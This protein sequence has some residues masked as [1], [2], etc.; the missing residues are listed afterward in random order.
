MASRV[1]GRVAFHRCTM[2]EYVRHARSR[3]LK[4]QFKR[5]LFADIMVVKQKVELGSTLNKHIERAERVNNSEYIENSGVKT[6]DAIAASVVGAASGVI[7]NAI[8]TNVARAASSVTAGTIAANGADA[9]GGA[10]EAPKA[11]KVK[12]S[13]STMR[14]LLC[15][16][17]GGFALGF[18]EFAM[19]G[20][21][22][23]VAQGMDVSI[24]YA[25]NYISAYAVGVCFGTLFLVFGHN[26]SPKKLLFFFAVLMVLGNGMAAI[27]PNS[28][29]LLVARFVAGLPH[30][31]YFGAATLV[32]KELAE[33]GKQAQAVSTMVLGQT[34]ANMVGVPFGTL[35]AEFISWRAAF[36]FVAVWAAVACFCLARFIPGTVRIAQTTMTGQFSFLRSPRPWFVLGA[37]F[38]GNI[39]IFCWWSYVSP[40]FMNLGGFSSQNLPALLMLCGFG[41]VLG[42]LAGGRWADKITPGRMAAAGQAL[43]CVALLLIFFVTGPF[44]CAVAAFL[45]SFAMFSMSSPQQLL[46]VKV[47][48]GGGEMIGSACV[49]VAYNAANAI[50]ALVGQSV[51]NAGAAY[52][53]PSLAG[54]PF[55][56][57]AAVLLLVF[58]LRFEYA[59]GG[60]R[61]KRFSRA[62]RAGRAE[63]AAGR[64]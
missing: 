42:S 28:P 50:G 37:V 21:L 35:L 44:A 24:P 10:S 19:M 1:L 43:S 7:E 38:A 60:D 57:T 29:A 17:M 20:I 15:L 41:M 45:C 46:M 22:P 61:D 4:H 34:A 31:A 2:R 13:G 64:S 30:G 49:Q 9:A 51:L 32:A 59:A 53:Y 47:G 27:A 6:A 54:A 11:R 5:G 58:A 16:A 52:N 3:S 36:A 14:S 39:G 55:A 33:P 62:V 18:A 12:R 63:S 26:I 23:S 8:A 48:A 56:A 25:G 40:W